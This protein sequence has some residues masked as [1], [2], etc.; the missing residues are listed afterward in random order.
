MYAVIFSPI[1]FLCILLL[2]ERGAWGKH[3]SARAEGPRPQPVSDVCWAWHFGGLGTPG[4][5][6]ARVEGGLETQTGCWGPFLKERQTLGPGARKWVPVYMLEE[7]IGVRRI[8]EKWGGARWKS[9]ASEEEG[10]DEGLSERRR[11]SW[12]GLPPTPRTI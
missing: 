6:C 2:E 1:Q 3:R 5:S 11:A 8:W 12:N 10:E 4:G 9:S 7:R